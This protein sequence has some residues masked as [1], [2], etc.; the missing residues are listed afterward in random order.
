GG[1]IGA[2]DES[3]L[4]FIAAIRNERSNRVSE[5]K[6][7]A[8][9]RV[10]EGTWLGLVRKIQFVAVFGLFSLDEVVIKPYQSSFRGELVGN[11]VLEDA[12]PT[13]DGD[14]VRNVIGHFAEQ[15]L[16]L[17]RSEVRDIPQYGG[18]EG[19]ELRCST[20]TVGNV[21][22]LVQVFVIRADDELNPAC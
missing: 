8:P 2:V 22:L 15:S 17:T 11:G 5:A 4:I 6:S 21:S 12:R 9:L 7:L 19:T 20:E 14:G 16:L 18:A 3:V 10:Q 1:H 13:S